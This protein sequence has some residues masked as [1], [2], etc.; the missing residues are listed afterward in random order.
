M[1]RQRPGFTLIELLV[2]IGIIAI[3]AG[4]LFPVFASA[5]EAARGS[6]C[7]SNL[8]QLGAAT[9][10][11]AQDYDEV[12][13]I[14]ATGCQDGTRADVCSYGNPQARI[15]AKIAPYVKNA[16]VFSCPR[17]RY[18]QVKWD[19]P[20]GACAWN[21][22]GYPDFLC[23]P[24][25]PNSGHSLGYGWNQKAFQSCTCT[26]SG[27]SLAQ[28]VFLASKG[29]VADSRYQYIDP[30]TVAFP[31]YPEQSPNNPP[32]RPP[33]LPSSGLPLSHHPMPRSRSSRDL[34]RAID[35]VPIWA[36]STDM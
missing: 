34:T 15:E 21:N 32:L 6:A 28:L 20:M 30:S 14:D 26:A 22:I 10:M 12:L 7:L 24:Q 29:M 19:A 1:Q 5:R 23:N 8:K 4:L 18:G 16:G 35:L 3:L 25:S 13:P 36:F 27:V 2:V 31:N 17:A 33:I 9:I 11:Y